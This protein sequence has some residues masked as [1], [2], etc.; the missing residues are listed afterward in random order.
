MELSTAHRFYHQTEG[1]YSRQMEKFKKE[2]K[3]KP[4]S[5]WGEDIGEGYTR[6]D[7]LYDEY[8]ELAGLAQM[9]R[10]FGILTLYSTLDHLLF[11][12]FKDAKDSKH[13]KDKAMAEKFSLSFKEYVRFMKRDLGIDLTKPSPSYRGL[14][15]LLAIRNTI[16]HYGGWIT[17][18]AFEKLKEFGFEEGRQLELGDEEFAVNRKLVY[19]TVTK[20][21]AGY[22]TFLDR[23]K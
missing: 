13:V 23:A 7:Q 5:Y 8:Q 16:A 21:V 6:S 10:S 19:D 9:N 18:E 20:I 17:P 22:R 2:E 4:D 3:S 12:I 14:R 1:F 15:R 11:Q